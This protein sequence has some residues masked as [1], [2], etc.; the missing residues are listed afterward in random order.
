MKSVKVRDVEHLKRLCA[1]EPRDFAM[2]LNGGVF[3]RKTIGWDGDR[4]EVENHIDDSLQQLTPKK[5][6]D[7]TVTLVGVAIK[8][9]A[10]QTC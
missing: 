3:S 5:L 9:G 10:L 2:L 8:K 4:F 6:M 1:K 7:K